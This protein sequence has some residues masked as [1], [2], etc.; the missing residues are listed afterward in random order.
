MARAGIGLGSNIGDKAGNIDRA[1]AALDAIPG[2]RVTAR[3][4]YYRTAP[5]GVTDQDWFVNACALVE[6]TLSPRALLDACL[7]IEAELGRKRL[8]R[9]GPRLIDLDILFFG[10]E[11][12]DQPGLTVPHPHLLERAFVLVPLADIAPEARI[13]ETRVIDALAKV[14]ATGIQPLLA[15][16]VAE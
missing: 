7:A 8:E 5:W 11:T 12:I 6:T 14:D 4:R 13:G 16:D 15:A 9:W 1:L 2:I 3:S 10:E